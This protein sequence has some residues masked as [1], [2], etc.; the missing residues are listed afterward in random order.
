M[1]GFLVGL[2]L[3]DPV[4]GTIIGAT[5]NLIYLGFIA[6]GGAIPGDPALAGVVATTLAVASGLEAE[7]ALALAVPIGLVGTLIWVSRMTVN[8][9]FV[10]W[11]D[12]YAEKG[13]Y[14]KVMLIN[15]IPPQIFLFIICVVPV[16]LAAI[17]GPSAVNSAL[18]FV[19]E[20]FIAALTVIGGMMPALGIALNLR[21]IL[22]KGNTVYY[23]LG[24][25]L[26]TYLELN[27]ISVGAFA[28]VIAY[29]YAQ[30]SNVNGGGS[31]DRA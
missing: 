2:I 11:A 3:G 15:V 24:F 21:A 28:V 19:G 14:R 29:I 30:F 8:S 18:S 12:K 25:L 16:A 26:S 13:D 10:H 6:A 7:T 17:Y 23:F 9:I 31:Y 20:D 1:N 27:I 22:K 4:Q 5:I